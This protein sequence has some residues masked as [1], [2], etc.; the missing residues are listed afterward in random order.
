MLQ[1]TMVLASHRNLERAPQEARRP[2][3]HVTWVSGRTSPMVTSCSKF[4]R[5][6]QLPG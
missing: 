4:L 6:V 5:S 1:G 3:G 2:R